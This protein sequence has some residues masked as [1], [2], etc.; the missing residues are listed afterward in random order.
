M[1]TMGTAEKFEGTI[2]PAHPFNA[3]QD[4]EILRKAMKGMG[5]RYFWDRILCIPSIWS[6]TVYF[7]LFL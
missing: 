5:M 6:T 4:C 3:E 7:F 2:K 1:A